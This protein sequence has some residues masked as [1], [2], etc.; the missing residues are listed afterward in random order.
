MTAYPHSRGVAVTGMLT[1]PSDL[2]KCP[3]YAEFV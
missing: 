1:I 2:L 3:F